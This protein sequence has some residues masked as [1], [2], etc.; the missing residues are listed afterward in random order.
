MK[1]YKEKQLNGGIQKQYKFENGYGASV[2]QHSG[3]YGNEQGL[4][5]LGVLNWIGE[6]VYELDYSTEITDDVIGYLTEEEVE[7]ILVRIKELEKFERFAELV[8]QDYI[9]EMNGHTLKMVMLAI[10]REREAC[11]ALCDTYT[12]GQWFAKAIRSRSEEWTND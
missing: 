2:I 10:Q 7:E 3:S 5:E 11:A 6:D 1:V 9:E 8:R 4:W 12:H